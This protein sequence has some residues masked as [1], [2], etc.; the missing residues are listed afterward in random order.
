MAKQSRMKQPSKEGKSTL[1]NKKS[2]LE[3]I[4]KT[5]EEDGLSDISYQLKQIKSM[6]SQMDKEIKLHSH[7]EIDREVTKMSHNNRKLGMEIKAIKDDNQ[8]LLA[9]MQN[10]SSN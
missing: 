8:F 3:S 7:D 4:T 5:S 2:F 9:R 6:M 10:I 1:K